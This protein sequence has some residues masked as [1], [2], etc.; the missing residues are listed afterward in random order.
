MTIRLTPEDDFAAAR[1]IHPAMADAPRL[2]RDS[3][4]IVVRDSGNECRHVR[5][6]TSTDLAEDGDGGHAAPRT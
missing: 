6:R 3:P 2:D 4:V 1:V 5:W